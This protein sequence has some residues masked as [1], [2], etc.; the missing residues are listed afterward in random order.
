[1]LL[2]LDCSIHRTL[3]L[4]FENVQV[5]VSLNVSSKLR[6]REEAGLL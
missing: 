1:V 6:Q 2:L 4:E 3:K 5:D